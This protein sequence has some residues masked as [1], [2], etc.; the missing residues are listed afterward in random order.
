V[1][2]AG[3]TVKNISEICVSLKIVAGILGIPLK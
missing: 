2:E 3:I 1:K